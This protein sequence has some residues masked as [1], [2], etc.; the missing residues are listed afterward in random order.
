MPWLQ[1]LDVFAL[2]SYANEGVPQAL[3]QAMLVGLPCVTTHVGSI[4]ELAQHETTALVVPPQDVAALRSRDRAAAVG[5]RS[6]CAAAGRRGAPALRGGLLAT[7]ACSTAWNRYI[8]K[9]VAATKSRW[10]ARL[11]IFRRI[12]FRHRSRERSLE[13]QNILVVAPLLIGDALMLA[14]LLAKL[15][16]RYPSAT[17]RMTM[18]P[19][20][21]PLFAGRPYGVEAGGY[22]PREAQSVRALAAAWPAPDLAFVAGDNRF[23]WLAAALGARWIVAFSGDRPAY[24]SWPVDELV[25]FPSAP[26][27]WHDIAALLVDGPPPAPYR[28]EW[29]KVPC[30]PFEQPAGRYAV[31]H[32]EASS[33]AKHWRE[34]NW[35]DLATRL[36][37]E[38]VLPVWSAGPKGLELI[39]RIDPANRFPA[40]GHTL[41]LAQ[42]W[43]LIAGARLLVCP[44]T[45]A[46]HMGKLAATPTVTLYAPGAAALFG[47]GE[48]WRDAPFLEL[49]DS[50]LAPRAPSLFKR[51]VRIHPGQ[52]RPASAAFVLESLRA[53]L[54]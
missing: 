5:R 47:R 17:I 21:V 48:F 49:V 12:A 22:N 41:D 24:K 15:R 26:A 6:G 30:A 31:L 29:G 8:G 7:S 19:A 42:L 54:G 9:R 27:A 18:A 51:P 14:P 38:N 52:D 10:P 45:G 43:N 34:A 16:A 3:V 1:A 32:V 20:A 39:R 11:E 13:P 35:L 40:V 2:P 37:G 4:A 36:S 50:T 23:S 28:R 53:L 25:P 33:P 46:S 44:D